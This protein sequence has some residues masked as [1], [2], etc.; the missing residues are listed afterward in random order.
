[1]N[2]LAIVFCAIR[3]LLAC[4]ATL[5]PPV[6]PSLPQDIGLIDPGDC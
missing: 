2:V 3:M 6:P 4:A 5:A 1:L